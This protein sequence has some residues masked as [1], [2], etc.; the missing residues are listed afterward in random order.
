MTSITDFMDYERVKGTRKLHGLTSVLPWE[1]GAKGSGWWL[2]VPK[3]YEFD[4]S[5]PRVFEWV[6][7]PFDRRVLLAAAIH[8]RLLD[9]GHDIAFASS[10]FRRACLVFGVH[11]AFAWVL[12]L[13]TLIWTGVARHFKKE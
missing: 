10:E 7:S 6:L 3:G 2:E 12:F 8:D 9:L 11:P 1:I 5:V 4:I 13:T